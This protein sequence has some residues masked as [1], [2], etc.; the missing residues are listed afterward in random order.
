[1]YPAFVANEAR[2]AFL[3]ALVCENHF[4][5]TGEGESCVPAFNII[6]KTFFTVS[7]LAFHFKRFCSQF[8]GAPVGYVEMMHSPVA[9]EAGA[10]VP[11]EIPVRPGHATRVI[12]FFRSRPTPH[13]PVQP[14]RDI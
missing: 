10:V 1:M 8:R 4:E 14:G 13:L 6:R 9:D 11:D 5:A 2:S 3:L 12:G 7:S